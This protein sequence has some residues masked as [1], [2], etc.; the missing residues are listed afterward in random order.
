ME[1]IILYGYTS[2][3]YMYTGNENHR[4]IARLSNPMALTIVS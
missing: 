2:N 3:A 1:Q 4:D